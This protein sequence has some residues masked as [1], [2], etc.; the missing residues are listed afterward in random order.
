MQTVLGIG[1]PAHDTGAA[2]I[3]NGVVAAAVNESRLSR[4]KRESRFPASS[5]NYLLNRHEGSIDAIA[6]S[7]V[8]VSSTLRNARLAIK[9]TTGMGATLDKL[10]REVY[11]S[12]GQPEKI[13]RRV[14]QELVKDTVID[15]DLATIQNMTSYI[16]HHL[17]HAASAFYTSGFSNATI[18]TVDSAGDKISSTVYLGSEGKL[19]KIASNS[20]VDSVGSLWSQIPTVFGFKGAK[21]AGKFMGMASYVDEPPSELTQIFRSILT[22][23]GLSIRNNFKRENGDKSYEQQVCQLKDLVGKFD[24][25]E[26]AK[27][28]QNRTEEILDTFTF[29]AVRKTGISDVALAGGVFA[30]VKVNQ[31]IYGNDQVD[32][33]F[34]HQNMGDGGLAVGAALE[35][36]ARQ[37]GGALKPKFLESVYLGPK[38]N[39]KNIRRAIDRVEIPDDY[40]VERF[41]DSKNLATTLAEALSKGEVVCLC[42]DRVEYGPRA[43]GNRS[44]LYQATD[45]TAIGWLNERLNRTEFMP[46]APVTL[47][48]DAE[49]CYVEFHPEKCP[50]AQFMTITF[51][52]TDLMKERSPGIVHVD[53]TARPQIIYE[54]VNPFYYKILQK[55]KEQTGIPTLINTSF[56]MHG[57][58]IVCKPQEAIQSFLETSNDILA[59][60]NTLIR[61][62]RS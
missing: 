50:A 54:R 51:T 21:H 9:N 47:A 44:I 32:K 34:V 6:L 60:D 49:E 59:I 57:E 11:V 29:N 5:I 4:E 55:Y 45:E 16:D 61:V 8:G 35:L 27:A 62:N 26:V 7:S 15:E 28:L 22:I 38:T 53:G 23:D 40:F 30:N 2:L 52:C 39:P 18:V 1:N 13:I 19:S 58:P 17:A 56:N 33:I 25:P 48:D 14:S 36:F 20:S 31:K 24:A 3:T 37:N 46:F 42:R 10:V 43:L 41:E 12:L